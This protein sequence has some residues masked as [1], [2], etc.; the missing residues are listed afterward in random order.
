MSCNVFDLSV[1]ACQ[2]KSRLVQPEMSVFDRI[3][4]L[5]DGLRSAEWVQSHD[6]PPALDQTTNQRASEWT[7]RTKNMF[8]TFKFQIQYEDRTCLFY[9]LNDPQI[10]VSS[11]LQFVSCLLPSPA[12]VMVCLLRYAQLIEHSHRCWVNTSALVSGCTNAVGLVMVGNFQV[13]VLHDPT[14]L[15]MYASCVDECRRPL[16]LFCL[17]GWSR[18][19]SPLRGSRGGVPSRAAVCVPAVCSHL[20][21]GCDR[22]RLLDGPLPG[23]SGTW[24]HGL[25]RPQYPL[26]TSGTSSL[27]CRY[28]TESLNLIDLFRHFDSGVTLTLL[29]A[30]FLLAVFVTHQ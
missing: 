14:L 15:K 16:R 29:T 5:W 20:P 6:R 9:I 19:V 12:V 28:S 3:H 22:P 18:Q 10:H 2:G 7:K 27:L 21:G 23:G 25:S 11:L 4:P 13:S 24:S 30:H 26:L 17:S 8:D 1:T